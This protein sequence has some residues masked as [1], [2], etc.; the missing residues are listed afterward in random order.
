MNIKEWRENMKI[1]E[2]VV[3]DRKAYSRIGLQFKTL[4]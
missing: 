3:A 2:D 4:K 1:T